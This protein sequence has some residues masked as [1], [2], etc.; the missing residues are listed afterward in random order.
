[1]N[2]TVK[3]R[4][5]LFPFLISVLSSLWCLDGDVQWVQCCV[6]LCGAVWCC[7]VLCGA[8]WCCVVLCGAV[9]CCV[10]RYLH[11]KSLNGKTQCYYTVSTVSKPPS[12]RLSPCSLCLSAVWWCRRTAIW[13]PLCS[14][15]CPV[16]QNM[17][18][19]HRMSQKQADLAEPQ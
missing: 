10:V 14:T 1:M 18:W 7:V 6:V 4:N 12:G 11:K 13:S 15:V 5:Y 2:V 19:G 16:A 8:V 17:L 9:W 3:Y